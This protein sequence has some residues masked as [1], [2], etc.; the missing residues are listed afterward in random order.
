M[1]TGRAL[2]G[3]LGRPWCGMMSGVSKV[4][5][6]VGIEKMVPRNLNDVIKHIKHIGRSEV[7]LAMGMAVGLIPIRG[8]IY[9]EM[10]AIETLVKVHPQII[11]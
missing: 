3:G 1:M 4:V 7:D 5:I 6:A 9:T 10:D 8:E 2:G 11:G